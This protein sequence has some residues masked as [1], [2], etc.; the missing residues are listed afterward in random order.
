MPPIQA[1]LMIGPALTLALMLDKPLPATPPPPKEGGPHPTISRGFMVTHHRMPT[2]A[3]PISHLAV[4]ALA[5]PQ[6]SPGRPPLAQELPLAVL[7]SLAA[8]QNKPP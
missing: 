3:V 1:H 6:H 4:A 5:A 2:Q 8:H 7:P